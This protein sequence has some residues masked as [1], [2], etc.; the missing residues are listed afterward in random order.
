MGVAGL[1]AV[2]VVAVLVGIWQGVALVGS[3]PEAGDTAVVE[4]ADCSPVDPNSDTPHMD[5]MQRIFDGC[6]V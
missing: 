6:D 2:Q 3:I 5:R 1:R 4:E